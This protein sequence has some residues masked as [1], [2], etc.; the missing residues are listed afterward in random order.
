MVALRSKSPVY[1]IHPR[2]RRLTPKS[3][4]SQQQKLFTATTKLVVY[5]LLSV[6]G[7][8]SLTNLVVYSMT[9]QNKLHQLK[10]EVKDA[11]QRVA[12]K[13]AEFQTSFDPRANKT[14][15]QENSYRI[16]ADQRP[17]ITYNPEATRR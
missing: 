4:T 9:Q 14:L 12:V 5:S 6:L 7:V 8:T 13:S 16:A 2:P 17:I 10:S 11:K 15:M 1:D 3:K